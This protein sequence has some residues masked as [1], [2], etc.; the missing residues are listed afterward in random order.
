M[1]AGETSNNRADDGPFIEIRALVAAELREAAAI[2]A[3]GMLD[4]PLHVA[5]FGTDVEHRQ[6]RLMRLFR[7]LTAYIEANG[8]VLGAYANG[9]LVGVL[10]MI[11]PGGCRPALLDR[12]RFVCMAVAST[13]PPD[14]CVSAAGCG[15][16]RV[17]IQLV[18]TGIS[19]R[20]PC[21]MRTDGE[22][23]DGT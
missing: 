11:E 10:G 5:V 22:A 8:Q 1:M 13:H 3:Q 12:L 9:E 7:H 18:R 6:K 2:L 21:G 19:V 17:T 4:N 14:C 16:G 20:W 15:R 23:S